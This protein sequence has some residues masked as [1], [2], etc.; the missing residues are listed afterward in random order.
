MGL[1]VN[2]RVYP[3]P[4]PFDVRASQER[5]DHWWRYADAQG[6]HEPEYLLPTASIEADWRAFTYELTA[7]IAKSDDELRQDLEGL[8][9][10]AYQIEFRNRSV[11]TLGYREPREWRFHRYRGSLLVRT[12]MGVLGESA[13]GMSLLD[14]GCHCGASALEYAYL[15]MGQVTGLDLRPENIRQAEWLASTYGIPNAR[16]V[17]DNVRNL[18]NYSGFDI[19][20][21]GGL[22]YHVTFPVEL[23]QDLYA[24]CNEFLVFDTA[25]AKDPVS[26]FILVMHKNTN[27]SAEGESSFEFQPTYRA[28]VDLL[29]AVGFEYVL[30][31]VGTRASQVWGYQEGI[32]RS[33]IAFKPGSKYIE[34]FKQA[35]G[36][37]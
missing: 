4:E 3:A 34:I 28:V 13:E 27:Y 8:G 1:K 7:D 15:G 17:T 16:F 26:T 36:V 9:A 2:R 30:E 20:F 31:L 35:L 21:C 14:V 11:S 32:T 6:L 19:T 33:F 10:W 24:S 29:C 23:M 22:L 5:F 18:R 25:A 12:V 37:P